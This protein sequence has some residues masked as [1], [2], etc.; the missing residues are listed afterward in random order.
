M[1]PVEKLLG[2]GWC[3]LKMLP[4]G[5]GDQ[6]RNEW[7]AVLRKPAIR[8]KGALQRQRRRNIQPHGP[9]GGQ[10]IDGACGGAVKEKVVFIFH[11]S[12][13]A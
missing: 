2:A 7:E 4:D 3:Y 5:L 11:Q 1:E 13:A 12:C 8:R 6:R 9:E 10:P